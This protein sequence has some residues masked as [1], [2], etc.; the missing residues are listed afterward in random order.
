MK[1]NKKRA[2]VIA[3]A[4]IIVILALTSFLI[5]SSRRKALE[6]SWYRIDSK[7]N[8]G[9]S[10]FLNISNKNAEYVFSSR[11]LTSTMEDFKWKLKGGSK[12]RFKSDMVD[13]T[14]SYELINDNTGL[15]FTPAL[16]SNK[17]SEVWYLYTE[18]E[19][20]KEEEE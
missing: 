4:V 10:Y 7:L 1:I 14:V 11:L 6:G 13:K 8:G 3:A 2:A 20:S 5:N 12:I 9:Y 17:A 18:D 16:S 19:E 15:V